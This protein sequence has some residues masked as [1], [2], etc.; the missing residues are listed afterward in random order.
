MIWFGQ[1]KMVITR[2][3]PSLFDPQ[4]SR[5][6]AGTNRDNRDILTFAE[7]RQPGQFGTPP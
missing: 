6:I 4:N 5:D 7:T 2:N 1:P 3:Q